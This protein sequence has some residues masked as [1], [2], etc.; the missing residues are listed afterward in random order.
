MV[1]DVFVAL[2]VGGTV[3]GLAGLLLGGLARRRQNLDATEEALEPE[4]G[5][6][7][8]DD[9]SGLQRKVDD[10]AEYVEM[11]DRRQVEIMKR[12]DRLEQDRVSEV[13]GPESAT[14]PDPV[15]PVDSPSDMI[16]PMG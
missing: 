13:P 15:L 12:L 11:I 10:L 8:H 6:V 5:N 3:F 7:V 4:E 2:V 16:E 14:E 1:I 9:R